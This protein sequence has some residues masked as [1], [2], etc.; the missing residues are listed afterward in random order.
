MLQ[1][2]R[3]LLKPFLDLFAFTQYLFSQPFFK[4]LQEAHSPWSAAAAKSLQSCP[5][6]WPHRRQ[7]T[8]LCRPWDSP[9][10]NTR[11]G[12]HCLL[13]HD[14]L[15]TPNS[16]GYLD[17]FLRTIGIHSTICPPL[18]LVTLHLNSIAFPTKL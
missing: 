3:S 2:P 16:L 17:S 13:R 18:H 12:C 15:P 14:L 9:G 7:P 6:V 10:K 1:S 8:R 5:T 11:V 4:R